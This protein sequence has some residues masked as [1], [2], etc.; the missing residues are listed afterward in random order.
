[1]YTLMRHPAELERLQAHPELVPTAVEEML[2]FE[3]PLQ[4]NPRRMSAD[5]EYGGALLR[6]GDYVLQMMGA[7]NRD[8]AQFPRHNT[9]DVGRT[10]NRHVGFGM[11]I[12]FCVG[13]PLARMEVPNAVG[14]LLKRLPNMQVAE[15]NLQWRPHGLLRALTKLPI[16][17]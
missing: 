8:A 3:G 13:A 11:G 2:R 7:A 10:P 14:T 17:F 4:R 5:Y 15:P 9:F 1:M 6:K 12:H 16:T